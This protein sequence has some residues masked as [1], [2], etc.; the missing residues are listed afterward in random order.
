M[1]IVQSLLLLKIRTLPKK[2]NDTKYLIIVPLEL[3][4]ILFIINSQ[5]KNQAA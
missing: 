3:I 4:F 5:I 2:G 1:L